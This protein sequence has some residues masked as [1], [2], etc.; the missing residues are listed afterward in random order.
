[1]L[2]TYPIVE[3]YVEDWTIEDGIRELISNGLDAETAQGAEL[4]IAH[5]SLKNVLT[6]T[7]KN[8]RLESSA[9]YFGASTKCDDRLIGKY[10]EGLKLALLVL[11]RAKM[12]VDILN[13]RDQTWKALFRHDKFGV[14]TLA[15][16][17]S[18]AK[19]A[20]NDLVIRVYGVD[21]ELWQRIQQKFLRLTGSKEVV[22]TSYG[23]LL[24]DVAVSGQVFCKGV[25]V[26]R[27][28]GWRYGYDLNDIDI[29]RDRK[30]PDS[31]DLNANIGRIWNE[32]SA[33]DP[34]ACTEIYELL[35]GGAPEGEAFR[36]GAPFAL[37]QLL[38]AEFKARHGEDVVPVSSA[39]DAE[40]LLHLGI[41]TVV[42][43]QELRDAFG[44]YFESPDDL[45]RKWKGSVKQLVD[46]ASLNNAE[47]SVFIA[48][49]T[50]L[51]SITGDEIKRL[52]I[53]E[54]V[55]DTLRG[56]YKDGQFHVAKSQL[57]DIGSFLTVAIH[58]LAHSYGRDGSA[59]HVQAMQRMTAAAINKILPKG[60]GGTS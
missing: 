60:P 39:A 33:Q 26:T 52:N 3:N 15:I 30:V 21:A 6:V 8:T 51:R 17:I 49:M 36:Y 22:S 14:S 58:E 10:G 23:K 48:G 24:K 37:R 56:Q 13:G 28:T 5:D 18:K 27:L 46:V 44:A 12:R 47:L 32:I 29:G 1:M 50:V 35:K 45:C 19:R 55:D 25:Y 57:A 11:T 31:Y 41:K 7:N 54:F 16:D 40:M 43:S 53:V 20:Y 2:F 59:T 38:S 34:K 4:I 9:L 42:V